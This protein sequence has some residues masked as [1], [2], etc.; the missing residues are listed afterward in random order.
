MNIYPNINIYHPTIFLDDYD[1]ASLYAKLVTRYPSLAEISGS[2]VDDQGLLALSMVSNST[3]RNV[4]FTNSSITDRAVDRLCRGCPDLLTLGLEIAV[5]HNDEVDEDV[6]QTFVTDESVHSIVKH[7]PSLE[8]LSLA[9]WRSITDDSMIA[10]SALK[11]LKAIN[12]SYCSGLTNVGVQHLLR[13]NGA[14]LEELTLSQPQEDDPCLYC[15]DALLHCIGECC[16]KLREFVVEIAF[17]VAEAS[18]IALAQ[19]CAELEVVDIYSEAVNDPFLVI[20]ADCCPHLRKLFLYYGNYTDIGVIAVS[21]KCA[22]L[23]VLALQNISDCSIIS[24]AKQCP[25]L[26]ELYLDQPDLI[27]DRGLCL[28]FPSCIHI[29]DLGLHNMPLITDRSILSF[30]QHCSTLELLEVRNCAGITDKGINLIIALKRGIKYFTIE[31]CLTLSDD[32]IRSIARHCHR[33]CSIEIVGCPLVTEQALL[34]LITH[35]K[36]LIDI[37]IKSC[38]V[39]ISTQFAIAHLGERDAVS[40]LDVDLGENGRYIL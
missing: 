4:R 18:L 11:S 7:C 19:G 33:L 30:V 9:G 12:L 29:T 14:N 36:R 39:C 1:H 6:G 17:P 34:A 25:S 13:N 31:S 37:T 35:G 3:L 22:K 21:S 26:S 24:L 5:P 32:T 27:T 8:K 10:L 28:L 23:K 40:D 20:L 15:N 38:S 2:K 16:P